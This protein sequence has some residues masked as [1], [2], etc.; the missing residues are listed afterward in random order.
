MIGYSSIVHEPRGKLESAFLVRGGARIV[1]IFL[2]LAR[3][4]RAGSSLW[5]QNEN[6]TSHSTSP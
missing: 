5:E 4:A 3:T 1:E 6:I 2:G